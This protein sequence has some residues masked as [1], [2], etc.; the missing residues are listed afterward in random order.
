MLVRRSDVIALCSIHRESCVTGANAMSASA[1]GRGRF[2]AELRTNVSRVG[3]GASAPS[4]GF[5]RVAGATVVSME[6]FRGPVRRSSSGA[7]ERGQ[8]SAA[9]WRSDW[10][11][12]TRANFCASANV[13][14][15]TGGPETGP[16]PKVG[17]APAVV[18]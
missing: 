13:D 16:V 8:L 11:M 2:A 18:D 15:D 12:V 6:T 7:I 4:I 5:H 9:I 1:A 3:E 10:V 14:A 17:G